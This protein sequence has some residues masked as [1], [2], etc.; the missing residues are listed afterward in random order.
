VT[1]LGR[2]RRA[3]IAGVAVLAVVAGGAVSTARTLMWPATDEV[4]PA[5]L[6]TSISTASWS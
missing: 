6:A 2:H 5:S 1:V 4:G 3:T